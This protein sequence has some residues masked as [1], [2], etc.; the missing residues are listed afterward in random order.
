M[1]TPSHP[2]HAGTPIEKIVVRIQVGDHRMAGSEDPLFLG[3]DG[4]EGREFRLELAKGRAL[5]RGSEDVF[6]LGPP[7]AD[8]TNVSNPDLNDPSSPA[9][10]IESV[11]GVYLRKGLEPIPN[12]RGLGEMDDRLQVEDVEV[13][14]H[15]R[16]R[17]KPA[18]FRRP[19]AFWLGLAAGLRLDLPPAVET[20]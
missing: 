19:G 14:L 5:R 18:R 2:Y 12:V 16:G 17:A 3:I 11:R 13:E 20:P 15:A 8:E 6:V 1:A 9:L 10:H 4:P 7:S